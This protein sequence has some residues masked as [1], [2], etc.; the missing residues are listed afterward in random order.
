MDLQSFKQSPF[1]SFLFVSYF[2]LILLFREFGLMV[3]ILVYIVKG[4]IDGM[5]TYFSTDYSLV[6]R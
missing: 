5:K 6:D 2:V 4:I 1:K 3:V